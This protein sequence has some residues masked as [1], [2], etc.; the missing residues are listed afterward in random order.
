[1][2]STLA[3]TA[4]TTIPISVRVARMLGSGFTSWSVGLSAGP[5]LVPATVASATPP[6]SRMA[7]GRNTPRV[8]DQ[9]T[10]FESEPSG[11]YLAKSIPYGDQP[12]PYDAAMKNAM[13]N[14]PNT[15][16]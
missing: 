6:T 4:P 12:N 10:D 5:Q 11:R 1:M 9:N 13:M 8:A 14:A 7:H 3:L 16:P 2:L 15:P